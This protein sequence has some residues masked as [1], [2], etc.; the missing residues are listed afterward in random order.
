M[1]TYGPDDVVVR[2]DNSSGSLVD[3]TQH[4]ISIDGLDIEALFDDQARSFGDVWSDQQPIGVKQWQP[5]TIE[6]LYD[7]TATTGPDAI[8][9][10]VGSIRTLELT[11]GG[12]KKTTVETYI[13]NYRRLPNIDRLTHYQ[14]VIQPFGAPTE[15]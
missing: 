2:Y 7:D 3:M 11:Y 15:A 13:K 14:V 12:T 1:A 9:N 5:V 6:G 4:V 10:S 8:F